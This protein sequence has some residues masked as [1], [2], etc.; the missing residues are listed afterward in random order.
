M[1][2]KILFS[3]ITPYRLSKLLNIPTSTIYSWKKIGIPAWRVEQIKAAAGKLG[4]D[5]SDCEV[6]NV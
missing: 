4:L 1:N 2:Y 6:S 5:L 3:K